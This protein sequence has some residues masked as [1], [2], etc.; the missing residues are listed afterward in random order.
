MTC[1]WVT[2]ASRVRLSSGVRPVRSRRVAWRLA[3]LIV[4][5]FGARNAGHFDGPPSDYSS[6]HYAAT[7]DEALAQ[8]DDGY[9][10]WIDGVR[11]LDAAAL[12]RPIGPAEG[13][14]SAEPYAALVLHINR[15]VLHHGA[16]ILLLRDLY[17]AQ[18]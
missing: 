13:E 11:S 6:W 1:S 3:H 10:R 2:S 7:A 16:E 12:E 8:L 15:E 17:R 14:W 9:T 4:G 5:I 18:A